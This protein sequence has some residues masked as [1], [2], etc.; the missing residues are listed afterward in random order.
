MVARL[1]SQ[2]VRL[3][4]AKNGMA[5]VLTERGAM[6]PE[7]RE[8]VERAW[9][10]LAAFVQ[11]HPLVCAWCKDDAVDLLLGGAPVCGVHSNEEIRP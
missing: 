3:A 1:A 11:G 8:Q 10:I 4:V 7:L 2:G 6:P 9:P 5:Y